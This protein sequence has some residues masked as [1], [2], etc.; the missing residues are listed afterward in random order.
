M[1]RKSARDDTSSTN[2][3]ERLI[4]FPTNPGSHKMADDT[5][6]TDRILL[7]PYELRRHIY[8]F[9]YYIDYESLKDLRDYLH[10][11]VVNDIPPRAILLKEPLYIEYRK[12]CHDF[13]SDDESW[14]RLRWPDDLEEA[15]L[16]GS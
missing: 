8:S 3:G 1:H 15:F 4:S 7:L 5:V 13:K 9:V 11:T 6:L 2:I 14:A 10:Y 12:Q 16:T